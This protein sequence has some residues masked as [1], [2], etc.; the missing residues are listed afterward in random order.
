VVSVAVYVLMKCSVSSS[1]LLCVVVVGRVC[2]VGR[3]AVSGPRMLLPVCHW[4]LEWNAST[5]WSWWSCLKQSLNSELALLQSSDVLDVHLRSKIQRPTVYWWRGNAFQVGPPPH[6]AAYM[7][8]L[9]VNGGKNK[10]IKAARWTLEL[11]LKIANHYSKIWFIL[12]TRTLR[13]N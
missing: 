10:K 13:N 6:R 1:F 3:L 11:W 5:V 12:C 2:F 7:W 4:M 8:V 9:H